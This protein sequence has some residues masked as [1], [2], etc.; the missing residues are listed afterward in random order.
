MADDGPLFIVDNAP[1]GRSGLDY[2]REWCELATTFDIATGYFDIAALLALD[3]HWQKLEGLRMLM[4]DEVSY[5]TKKA[6]LEAVKARA[7]EQL[8][9]SIEEV[10]RVDPFLEGAPAVVAAL[11]EKKIDCRVYNR[12]KFHAKAYITHGKFDVLGSQALVG[13]SNFTRAGLTQNVELNIKIE[14]SSEVAQLQR[15]YEQHWGDAVEVTADILKT[16]ERHTVEHSPF[17]VYAA[18]LRALVSSEEPSDLVWDQQTSRMYPK[19][20]RYQAEAYASLVDIARQHGGP[21]SA[22]AWASVRR[23]SG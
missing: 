14:S 9:A 16:I 7:S 12:D 11:A 1:G 21:S 3:G 4:G 17:Q 6:L 18:A 22:T 13:S 20:D 8:D 23:M 10:K 2:L 15:W 19:L 5:R